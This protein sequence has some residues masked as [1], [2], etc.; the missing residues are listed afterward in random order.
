MTIWPK[1]NSCKA[2]SF[3]MDAETHDRAACRLEQFSYSVSE[4][5]SRLAGVSMISSVWAYLWIDVA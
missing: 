5:H 2:K 1:F 3:E 4:Y